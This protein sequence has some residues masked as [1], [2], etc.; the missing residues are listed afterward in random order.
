MMNL[1]VARCVAR[2]AVPMPRASTATR[3]APLRATHSPASRGVALRQQARS[4]AVQ[5]HR[6]AVRATSASAELDTD[7]IEIDGDEQ[8]IQRAI[9]IRGNK[10]KVRLPKTEHHHDHL[11]HARE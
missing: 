11:G 8:R 1:N 2:G 6:L 5:H 10:G 4:A 9:Q 7:E 3:A